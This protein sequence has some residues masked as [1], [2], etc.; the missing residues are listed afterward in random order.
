MNPIFYHQTRVF[1]PF[2]F[3]W[4]SRLKGRHCRSQLFWPQ[5][6]AW[7][8]R[9]D[10]VPRAAARQVGDCCRRAALILWFEAGWWEKLE[11]LHVGNPW[12]PLETPITGRAGR[13]PRPVIMA[14]ING[15]PSIL[16]W[17]PPPD[18]YWPL[19]AGIYLSPFALWA[20]NVVKSSDYNADSWSSPSMCSD[21]L[22]RGTGPPVLDF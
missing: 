2:W 4:I 13:F 14:T 18:I 22:S 21:N 6:N 19:N 5:P 8:R 17:A 16:M 7:L 10:W 15:V 3:M 20:I 11:I 1:G 12:K 9:I